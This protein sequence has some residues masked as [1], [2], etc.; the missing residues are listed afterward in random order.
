MLSLN[1]Y[2]RNMFV[3]VMVWGLLW[4]AWGPGWR[5]DGPWF[6]LGAV[7]VVGWASGQVLQA[8]TTMPPL[9]AALLTGILARN[10]GFLDMRDFIEIDGFLRYC[11]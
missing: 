11:V 5:W 7:A 3:G 10:I 4:C 6:R 2:V 1:I 9:L 8:L